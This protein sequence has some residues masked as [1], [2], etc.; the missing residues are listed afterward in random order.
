[1]RSKQN[2]RLL[3]CSQVFV[4]VLIAFQSCQRQGVPPEAERPPVP[5]RIGWALWPGWYPMILAE[6]TGIFRK[7]RVP[8][9]PVLLEDY[10]DS[11]PQL[12]AGNL[13]AAL[14]GLYETLKAGIPDA[15]VVMITD[16]SDGAEGLVVIPE[17]RK[18]ADLRGKRVGIQGALSGSE[19]LLNYY[20]RREGISPHELILV[21][22]SPEEIIHHMPAKI[23][24]GYTWQPF[25]QEALSRRYR[26]LFTTADMP[27]MIPDVAVFR[28]DVT[29]QRPADVRRFIQ[30]WFEAVDYWKLHTAA[31]NR[32]IAAATGLP[33]AEI[34]WQGCRLMSIDDNRRA[35]Q[36]GQDFSSL[37][38]CARE[39]MRFFRSVGDVTMMPDIDVILD[40]SYLK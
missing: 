24:A 4:L 31:A 30:A 10:Q 5:L 16:Y 38:H 36:D 40:S 18:P 35:F 21:S 29:R 20:L 8:V 22:I 11:L 13:D 2:H 12:Q 9:T 37:R 39:Q 6:R 28:E 33:E 17:I 25:L 26:L 34:G 19:F 1:M 27:G 23:E 7:H 15:R 14:S 32:I 3:R